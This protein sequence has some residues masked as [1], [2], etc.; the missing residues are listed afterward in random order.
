MVAA[1]TLVY[2]AQRLRV[3]AWAAEAV[4]DL[5][6]R[7][8]RVLL[9]KGP[10]IARWLYPH[11]P[12]QRGYVDVDLLVAPHDREQTIWALRGLGYVPAG[13][14][15]LTVDEPHARHYHRADGAAVDLHRVLHGTEHLDPER[16]W[17][18]V[19]M[20]SQALQVAGVEMEIP[21]VAARSL[22]LV[23]HLDAYDDDEAQ[24]WRDLQRAIIALEPQTWA[25]A[26]GLARSLGIVEDFATR[27]ARPP[28]GD[29]IVRRLGLQEERIDIDAVRDALAT[30]AR[31]IG[32]G[33][34]RRLAAQ[35]GWQARTTYVVGKLLPPAAF[36]YD[37]D[38]CA[39]HSALAL[40]HARLRWITRCAARLTRALSAWLALSARH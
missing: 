27:L 28:G 39:Q 34:L 5:R 4:S 12:T 30:E 36:L 24:A 19:A 16:V 18:A 26:A 33:S 22:H 7:G 38:C 14:E 3:D 8:V 1:Q 23:L 11:D 15:V 6:R 20:N 37:H 31:V 13:S 25:Q 17:R 21:G 9:L 29:E 10:A 32:V 2:A 40:A 35:P